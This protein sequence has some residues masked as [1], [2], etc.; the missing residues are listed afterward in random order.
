MPDLVCK[1]IL[2]L[3]FHRALE[4]SSNPSSSMISLRVLAPS[5]R[6]LSTR[7]R[8]KSPAQRRRRHTSWDFCR[9]SSLISVLIS[10]GVV[11]TFLRF[12]F[13]S[14]S[15]LRSELQQSGV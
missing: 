14:F 3:R 8:A 13:C 4:L 2:E 12:L 10:M 6:F 1:F 5:L 11:I 9:I 15:D 7:C